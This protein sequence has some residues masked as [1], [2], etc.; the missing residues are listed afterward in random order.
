MPSV[1]SYPEEGSMPTRRNQP[2]DPPRRPRLRRSPEEA[3]RLLQERIELGE[4]LANRINPGA[5]VPGAFSELEAEYFSWSS[6]NKELLLTL[7]DTDEPA[8][9]YEPNFGFA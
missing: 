1:L 6:Y 7:F 5:Y 2:V 4:Q 9:E 3:A 8:N